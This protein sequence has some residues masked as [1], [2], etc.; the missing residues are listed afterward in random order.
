MN[1]WM[2]PM[3]AGLLFAALGLSACQP[4]MAPSAMAQA[5]PAAETADSVGKILQIHFQYDITTDE[6]RAAATS[7][8]D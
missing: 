7:L 8:A 2:I 1:K 4:V 5:A 6:Y 3:L